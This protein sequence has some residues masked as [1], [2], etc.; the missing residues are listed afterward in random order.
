[1]RSGKAYHISLRAVSQAGPSRCALARHTDEKSIAIETRID[2]WLDDLYA[3]P[4]AV[5]NALRPGYLTSGG[6][7]GMIISCNCSLDH[8]VETN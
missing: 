7:R 2:D 5:P 6:V 3:N 8:N 1:M 4:L